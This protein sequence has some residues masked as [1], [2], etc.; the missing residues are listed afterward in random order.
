MA[1]LGLFMEKVKKLLTVLFFPLPAIW[2]IAICVYWFTTSPEPVDKAMVFFSGMGVFIILLEYLLTK[3]K[4]FQVALVFAFLVSVA[5]VCSLLVLILYSYAPEMMQNSFVIFGL[6]ILIRILVVEKKVWPVKLVNVLSIPIFLY[7]V[8]AFDMYYPVITDTVSLDGY[9]YILAHTVIRDYDNRP[10]QGFYKCKE[11]T[12]NCELLVE[13][14]NGPEVRIVLDRNK[15]VVS[16]VQEYNNNLVY[17]FGR[18]LEISF[19][20]TSGRFRNHIYQMSLEC[21]NPHWVSK[22]SLGCDS[23]TYTLHECDSDFTGC[24]P[25]LMKYTSNNDEYFTWEVD[26]NSH[27]INLYSDFNNTEPEKFLVLTYGEHPQCYVNGCQIL[28]K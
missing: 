27:Q 9:K 12:L 8:C 23:Y 14:S 1:G 24:H 4:A 22:Y 18:K 11:S 7:P 17:S 5:S 19:S 26:E 3:N 25:L 28:K 20:A 16:L 13:N 2:L 21:N 15:H 10:T 6:L